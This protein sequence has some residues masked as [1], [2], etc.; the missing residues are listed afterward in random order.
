MNEFDCNKV[1]LNNKTVSALDHYKYMILHIL[2][3]TFASSTHINV[4]ITV[5]YLSK[6][7]VKWQNHHVVEIGIIMYIFYCTNLY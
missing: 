4:C 1:H 2:P 3:C 7:M 6:Y 5:Y